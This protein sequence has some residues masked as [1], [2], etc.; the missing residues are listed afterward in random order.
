ME[1]MLSLI[2]TLGLSFF[3]PALSNIRL[4]DRMFGIQYRG[5]RMFGMKNAG[6][7]E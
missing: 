1:K 4:T 6:C 5:C 7:S 2:L 3:V